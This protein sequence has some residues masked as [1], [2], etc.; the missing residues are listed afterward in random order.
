VRVLIPHAAVITESGEVTRASLD[1]LIRRGLDASGVKPCALELF[2]VNTQRV[3]FLRERQI[4]AA[5]EIT[6]GQMA[7]TTVRDFLTSSIRMHFP[8]AALYELNTRML[9]SLLVIAQKK[10]VLRVMTNLVDLDEMLNRIEA[11]GKSSIVCAVR[12]EYLAILRYEKGKAS[13]LCHGR[14]SKVPR[15][16][17]LREEFLVSVY[18]QAAA[19]PLTVNLYED[20]M[21]SYAP[22]AR[23]VAEGFAGRF[24]DL[25]LSK[26]PTLLLRL[27]D[28]EIGRWEMD[29]PALKVGR[30]PDN[31]IVIDNLAVS[32]LHAM[33][34]ESKGDYFVRDCDSLNGT[35]VNGERVKRR[36]RTVTRSPSPHTIVFRIPSDTRCRP[37]PQAGYDRP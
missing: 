18:T 25:F 2:D 10:P 35:E 8:A 30:T 33:I 23:N 21:V 4:Y 14:L 27:K 24:D 1:E 36:L 19:Q 37:K 7:A 5:A 3:L 15:E 16:N 17:S 6:A 29:R 13:A 12:D 34:E 28:R 22:D 31:D 26:P 20:F 11:D 9:H 32:R